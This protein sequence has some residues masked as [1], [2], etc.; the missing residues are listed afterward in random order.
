MKHL[1]LRKAISLLAALCLLAGFSCA[2]AAETTASGGVEKL[3]VAAD[4]AIYR[5]TAPNGQE[6][7]FVADTMEE[8]AVRLE[9]VNFDGADDVVI[10]T[11][12]GASN[13]YYEF[14]VWDGQQYVYA[15]PD[16]LSESGLANYGLDAEKGYVF[17]RANNGM[18]G[19]EC[20][21]GVYRWEGLELK[22][23]RVLKA[24]T[25]SQW[26]DSPD[27]GY[28]FAIVY[29]TRIL[30]AAV[31]DYTADVYEGSVIWEKDFNMEEE[32]FDGAQAWNEMES[33]LMAGL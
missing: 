9:D 16:G 33:A 15:A 31:T 5:Y 11:R 4:Q 21:D 1:N 6:L 32:G 22:P 18:A 30:H 14:Y 17:S 29:D 26:Q 2:A 27:G 3:T 12:L 8:P 25:K 13:A 7:Y 10:T 19:L 28:S 23:V 24:E 20:E